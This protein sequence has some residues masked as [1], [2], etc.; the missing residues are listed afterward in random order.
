M[1]HFRPHHF[2][3]ALGFQG[4]GYSNAFVENFSNIIKVINAEEGQQVAIKVTFEADAIC[5]PCPNRRETLCTEQGKI[6]RL[7]RAH[8][9]ALQ[10]QA[11]EILNWK[12]AKERIRS[13]VSFDVFDQICDGCSWKS[14]G[15]CESALR[16]LHEGKN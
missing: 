7:D 1:I 4:S 10:L 15:F 3:C 13:R 6:E 9:A 8:A 5:A 11:G 14:L 12:E 16:K 2:M